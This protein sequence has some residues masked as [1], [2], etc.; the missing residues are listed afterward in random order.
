[1]QRFA[2]VE[3]GMADNVVEAEQQ[4]DGWLPCGDASPGWLYDDLTGVFSPPQPP[5]PEVPESITRAQGKAALIRAGMW[6]AVQG[7]VAGIADPIEQALAEVAL[8]DTLTW[9]R[10]SPFLNQAAVALGLTTEQM[11]ALFIDAKG[12]EL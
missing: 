5:Q 7:F 8:N 4:P 2:R 9:R 10:D 1:M 3:R 6:P 12:I 11:D